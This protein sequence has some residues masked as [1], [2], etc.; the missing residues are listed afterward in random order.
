MN[1]T[2]RILLAFIIT[3]L[4]TSIGFA[5]PEIPVSEWSGKTIL[6]VGAHPDDDS[7]SY[8]TLS[9]LQEN[10]NEVYVLLMTMGNVGTKDPDMTRDRLAKIRRGEE[11]RA[12]EEIGIPEENYINLGYN[13]GMLEFTD[14]EEVVRRLVKWYRKIKPDVLFA[15]DP[16]FG[17][18][19]W[20]KADHRRASYLA[21]DAARAAE[22]RLLFPGQITQDGLEK[23][24]IKEYMFFSGVEEDI[25]T[26]VDIP[27]QHADRKFEAVSKHVSQF[28]AAWNDYEG[29]NLEA[30]KLPK[31]DQKAF[32]EKMRKRVYGSK[33][34]GATVEGFRYYKGMP[35]G[36]GHRNH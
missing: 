24:R 15:F 19:K 34:D 27:G 11:I 4:L 3:A 36:I 17:Y 29:S 8:G 7:R 31:E 22:W 5:Q 18:Q 35:D 1:L 20:L 9:M 10:G 13:D 23:H 28:S 21:V 25:N 30:E 32:L 6:L 16:G 33:K 14:R 26:W 2:K 12:L